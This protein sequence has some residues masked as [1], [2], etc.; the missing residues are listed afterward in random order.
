LSQPAADAP[1][2]KRA[3]GF[4]MTTALVVGN[5]IGAGIFV[6]PAALAPFGLNALTGWLVTVA[7]CA[8]LAIAFADL[9]RRFPQDDGPYA[10]TQRAFGPAAAFLVMWCYWVSVWVGNAAIAIGVVGYVMFLV[11]GL[12]AS[13]VLPPLVALALVWVFVLINL[14]GV[15][16]AGWV[17]ML[18]TL[19][20]LVPQAAVV[21]LGVT[22]LLTHPHVFK[23]HVPPN[24]ASWREVAS[25]SSIALFSMLG[26]ECA[27][28]PAARVRDPQRTIPRATLAGTLLA[29]LIYICISVVPMFLIP[30]PQLAASNAPFADLFAQR[31]GGNWGAVLAAFVAVSGLGALNGWTLVIGEVTQSMAKHRG[32]PPALAKENAHAAPARAFIFTGIVT[33]IML[34]CNY[35]GSVAQMFVFLSLIATNLT[36]PLY[37]V[38][39]LAVLR[40]KNVPGAARVPA[41]LRA[42]AAVLAALYC[43][44]IVYGVER[45]PLLA[46]IGF[47]LAGVPVYLW[48]L[49]RTNR[50]AAAMSTLS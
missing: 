20:K 34:L 26:I 48:S 23:E 42:A 40:L 4:W 50:A 22:L 14:R 15:R 32:F 2:A 31:L 38:D 3:L 43:G 45:R 9:A 25:V 19:L 5:I 7:G 37:L 29:A 12:A 44:W 8:C 30:Q 24:P 49:R 41:L 13:T 1:A 10:Y 39:A 11:P 6:M 16:A 28:I 46:G 21:L 35:V 18:T 33:S 47:G 17:Q 36:L 27:T